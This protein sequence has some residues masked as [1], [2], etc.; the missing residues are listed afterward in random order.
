MSKR[1]A[2]NIIA[3]RLEESKMEIKKENLSEVENTIYDCIIIGGGAGGL[4]AGIYLQRFLL[5]SLIL[6]KGKGRS[7]W[8][9]NLTN[10]MGIPPNT[11]GHQILKQ[12][13]NHYLSLE[14][15]YLNCYADDVIDEGDIF[16]IKVKVGKTNTQYTELRSKYIIAASGI[17]DILP[18]LESM[19]NVFDYAGYNL[20][21]CMVC[22]GYEMKDK[23]CGLFV[24]SDVRINTAFNLAWFTKKIK[25]FTNNSF[26]V[27]A[28]QKQRILDKGF[29]LYE[30]PIKQFLGENHEMSGVEL[31]N[32]EKII[33]ETGLISMG[34]KY[35]N[36][37][38]KSVS[39]LNWEG[40]N[41]ITGNHCLT[42]HPRIFA[43]GDIK[44]GLNQVS[45]AVG[46]GASAAHEI[47]RNIRSCRYGG[48]AM[49]KR[50]S[51]E[52]NLKD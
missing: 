38:L 25:I 51:K 14:G 8:I 4:S 44:A 35:H 30:K 6:D 45:I 43:I 31:E 21:V 9:Q 18:E 36:N 13:K 2:I 52:A 37:Y 26:Q 50:A 34:S 19:R 28:E 41:L 23:I 15:D 7:V 29:E 5:K 16:R 48:V 42:S 47:W 10:Y 12:G 49:S 20:H 32:G 22:D 17:I 27:S 3:V 46:D 11:P 33:L 40:E 1:K 24:N 39:G